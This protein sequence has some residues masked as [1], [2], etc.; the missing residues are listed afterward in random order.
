M[1]LTQLLLSILVILLGILVPYIISFLRIKTKSAIS[2][3]GNPTIQLSDGAAMSIDLVSL[4][5]KVADLAFDIVEAGNQTLV[6]SLKETGKFDKEAQE[7]VKAEA[8]ATLK[9]TLSDTAKALLDDVVDDLDLW[10]D[11]LI[12]SSVRQSKL[13]SNR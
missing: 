9:A 1:T 11:T 13:L 10:L 4:M 2:E 8:L 12:E 7:K 5:S 3:L 6:D